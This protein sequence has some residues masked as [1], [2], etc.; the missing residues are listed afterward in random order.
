MGAGGKERRVFYPYLGEKKT[1]L[2]GRGD[3]RD[4]RAAIETRRRARGLF[5]ILSVWTR[6][7]LTSWPRACPHTNKL[8][9]LCLGQLGL[10]FG[11]FF[12]FWIF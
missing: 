3:D 4:E 9:Q 10:I 11:I 8:P 5:H 2:E 6:G 7:G 1:V 12:G